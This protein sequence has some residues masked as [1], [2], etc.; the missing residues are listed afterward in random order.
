MREFE[1]ADHVRHGVEETTQTWFIGGGGH[2][3]SLPEGPHPR[4]ALAPL[5]EPKDLGPETA[6]PDRASLEA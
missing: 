3:S 2:A 4:R 6:P 1:L 5:A